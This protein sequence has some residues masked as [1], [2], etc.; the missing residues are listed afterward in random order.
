MA[1]LMLGIRFRLAPFAALVGNR[2]LEI[3]APELA[4]LVPKDLG[5]RVCPE[6]GRL[7]WPGGHVR[8]MQQRLAFWQ[9][10]QATTDQ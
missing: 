3:A 10:Q 2:S 1:S 8:R 4:A 6:C 5:L 7:Y 9:E